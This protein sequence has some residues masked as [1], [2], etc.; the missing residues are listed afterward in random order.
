MPFLT[1]SSEAARLAIAC[2]AAKDNPRNVLTYFAKYEL[3]SVPSHLR[4]FETLIQAGMNAAEIAPVLFPDTT[5]E[6]TALAAYPEL[7]VVGVSPDASSFPQFSKTLFDYWEIEQVPASVVSAF[8]L[9][10]TAFIKEEDPAKKASQA[11]FLSL[12][13]SVYDYAHQTPALMVALSTILDSIRKEKNLYIKEQK[14]QWLAQ[15][16]IKCRVEKIK[17]EQLLN[18]D[19]LLQSLVDL[20]DP[21]LRTALINY[22]IQSL[23]RPPLKCRPHQNVP[24]MLLGRFVNPTFA[25]ITSYNFFKDKERIKSLLRSLYP[26]IE[27]NELSDKEKIEILNKLVFVKNGMVTKDKQAEHT[28]FAMQMVAQLIEGGHAKR[29]PELHAQAQLQGTLQEILTSTLQLEVTD[30]NA[31]YLSTFGDWRKPGSFLVYVGKILTLEDTDDRNKLVPLLKTYATAVLENTFSTVRYDIRHSEHLER[32]HTHFPELLTRWK[33]GYAKESDTYEII[34]TD[35]PCDLLLSGTEVGSCQSV[36]KEPYYSKCLTNY[37]LDGKVRMM[38]IKNKNGVIQARCMLRLLWDQKAQQFALFKEYSYPKNGNKDHQR[39]LDAACKERARQLGVA[40]LEK[41]SEPSSLH[42]T[43]TLQSFKTNT[44]F[45]YVDALGTPQQP[46][47]AIKTDAG[48]EIP[49][50]QYIARVD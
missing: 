39:I 20:R 16:F 13:Q 23:E 50:C 25:E 24:L 48:Y 3:K 21:S 37:L 12:Y 27:T 44:P 6:S 2:I 4:L 29:L 5:N 47:L 32:V 28:L 36:D 26:L 49:N 7:R 42:N 38:A 17:P 34:D 9:E 15:F 35:H 41:S 40:L 19:S 46:Y 45:E 8:H 18:R 22:F 30:F 33:Q 14:I 1:I 11:R 43:T 31:K 10:Y